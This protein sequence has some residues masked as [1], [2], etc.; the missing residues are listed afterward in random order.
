MAI[1]ISGLK[2]LI[3]HEPRRIGTTDDVARLIHA[4]PE[5]LRKEFRKVEG[6]CLH[7]YVTQVKVD[8]AKRLL[9]STPLRCYEICDQVGF[10]G[11]ESGGRTFK[12]VAGLSMA[13]YR[14][15]TSVT[16]N[17]RRLGKVATK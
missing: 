4:S 6:V 14:Q 1:D 3:K 13:E 15:C 10:S 17:S 7:K 16:S 2:V 12:R 5:T 11:Q 8:M 9:L